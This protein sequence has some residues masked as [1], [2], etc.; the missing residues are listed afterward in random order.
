MVT[1]SFKKICKFIWPRIKRNAA[2]Q[3]LKSLLIY[4]SENKSLQRRT[5][6]AKEFNFFFQKDLH[7]SM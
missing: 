6:K 5:F 4:L 1:Q 7:W 3:F 2:G